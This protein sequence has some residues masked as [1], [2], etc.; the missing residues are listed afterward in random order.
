M[1]RRTFRLDRVLRV[2]RIEER[3]AR[4]S[5]ASA[6]RAAAEAEEACGEA[7]ALLASARDDLGAE[8]AQRG[9]R[10]ERVLFAERGLDAI[11]AAL[12]A[13]REAAL[14]RRGQADGLAAAWRQRDADRRALEELSSR[15]QAREAE[16]E[17][18][19]EAAESDELS[20]QRNARKTFRSGSSH[21]ADPTDNAR[22][23]R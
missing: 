7:R 1:S 10:P 15:H 11:G 22:R 6:E 13:R 17:R 5:W 16:E 18:A 8:R 9:L 20:I 21:A 3:L 14:T 2:R 23:P 4:S 12:S 19:R